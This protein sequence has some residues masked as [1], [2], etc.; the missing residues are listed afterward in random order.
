MREPVSE[1][2][3]ELDNWLIKERGLSRIM[4][5]AIMF[6]L[7]M[8]LSTL[9]HESV[10]VA[11]TT[12]LQCQA[13]GVNHVGL[14]LGNSGLDCSNLLN[15]NMAMIVIAMSA[16]IFMALLGYYMWFVGGKDNEYTRLFGIINLFYGSL[17][18]LAYWNSG[19]DAAVA[20]SY[21]LGSGWA[22]LIFLSITAISGYLISKEMADREPF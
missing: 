7:F 14:F 13:G 19:T 4:A 2:L 8:F 22:M 1:V 3:D 11:A 20:V 16:P 5:S 6:L 9:I 21:G 18:N 17:P 15:E 10:H 12:I